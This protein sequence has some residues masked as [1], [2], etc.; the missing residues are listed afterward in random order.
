MDRLPSLASTRSRAG[1]SNAES[2]IRPVLREL[3]GFSDETIKLVS[4]EQGQN[5]RPVRGNPPRRV[6]AQQHVPGTR[7]KR[8]KAKTIDCWRSRRFGRNGALTIKLRG[9]SAP[10]LRFSAACSLPFKRRSHARGPAGLGDVGSDAVVRPTES[11]P[12][13]PCIAK[14]AIEKNVS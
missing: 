4:G 10:A 6:V 5:T 2:R 9:V 12:V 1:S 7:H 14:A 3:T 11:G 13:Q 8:L